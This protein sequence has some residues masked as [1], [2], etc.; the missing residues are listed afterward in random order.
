MTTMAG[1]DEKKSRALLEQVLAESGGLDFEC[2]ECG[3]S[4]ALK[5]CIREFLDGR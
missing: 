3:L 2:Q 5:L 1:D 4:A